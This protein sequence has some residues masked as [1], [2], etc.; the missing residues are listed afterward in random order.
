MISARYREIG[1]RIENLQQVTSGYIQHI[2]W[3]V[4]KSYQDKD[5]G[6]QKE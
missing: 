4:K 3:N 5:P 6:F 1:A 2:G